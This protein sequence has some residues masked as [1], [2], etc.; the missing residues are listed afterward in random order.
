M[1]Q[2][3]AWDDISAVSGEDGVVRWVAAV[4]I[5]GSD[6][7]NEAAAALLASMSQ[8]EAVSPSEAGV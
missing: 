2:A 3:P 7:R 8:S 5:H 4:D 6:E 1:H